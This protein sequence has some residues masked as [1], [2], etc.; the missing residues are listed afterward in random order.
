[1]RRGLLWGFGPLVLLLLSA[2]VSIGTGSEA[3][4]PLHRRLVDAGAEPTRR[5]QPLVDALLIQPLP[6]D[7]LADT[8]SIAYSRRSDEFAFYQ[9]ASWTERPVR[10]LPRLLQRRLEARGV[11]AAVGLLGEPL[12]ADWLLTLAV[13]T[14]HHDVSAPP[15]Q[16]RLAVTVELF[17]RRS[18]AR[19]ARRS[20]T[21]SVPTTRA[22]S[23]A[24]AAAMS[25]AV[26]AVFDAMLP[27][28]EAE[29]ERA[30]AKSGR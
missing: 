15:G 6:A 28:L 7:A 16:A 30:T 27:W 22:D 3:G 8:V 24:A 18:P 23:A 11:A 17:D 12:R 9:L 10:Q 2:C 25:Q 1:M 19:V 29:L 21:A 5:A 14:L 26:A 13:D 4:P 20:F